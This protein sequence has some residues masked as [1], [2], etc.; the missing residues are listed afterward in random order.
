MAEVD[1]EHHDQVSTALN[2]LTDKAF[3]LNLSVHNQEFLSDNKAGLDKDHLTEVL[4][5]SISGR[6]AVAVLDPAAKHIHSSQ[7]WRSTQNTLR[8]SMTMK[9]SNSHAS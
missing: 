5:S 4:S 3:T 6:L 2:R 1:P 8:S 9:V 7:R